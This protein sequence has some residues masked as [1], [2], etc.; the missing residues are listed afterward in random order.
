M[1]RQVTRRKVGLRLTSA[2]SQLRQL[3]ITEGGH[4]GRYLF[5]IQMSG[6]ERLLRTRRR[7]E[8]SYRLHVSLMRLGYSHRL[9]L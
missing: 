9:F 1:I 7:Q 5:R 8:L 3:L 4:S 6:T 2:R